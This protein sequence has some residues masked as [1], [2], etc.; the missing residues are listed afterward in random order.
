M[1]SSLQ[2]GWLFLLFCVAMFFLAGCAALSFRNTPQIPTPTPRP[3][4]V[5]VPFAVT[6]D[7]HTPQVNYL[8]F[9]PHI[10]VNPPPITT[11]QPPGSVPIHIEPP[12]CYDSPFGQTCLGRIWNRTGQS[13][14]NLVIEF[15]DTHTNTTQKLQRVG[16]TQQVLAPDTFSPYRLQIAPDAEATSFAAA[17]TQLHEN[18]EEY[19]LLSVQASAGQLNEDGRFTLQATIQNDT[20]YRVTQVRAVLTLFDSNT[21]DA[22]IVGYRVVERQTPLP[23]QA[24][25]TLELEIIPLILVDA[26]AFELHAE[27]RRLRNSDTTAAE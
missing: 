5:A 1:L 22:V 17:V 12:T 23:A 9:T 24:E 4:L 11:L 14:R 6:T 15:E 3:S 13:L 25:W 19:V 21:E 20:P 18:R 7:L 27:G 10:F 2:P 26:P 16:L 8:H